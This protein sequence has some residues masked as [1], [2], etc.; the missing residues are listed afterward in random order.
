MSSLRLALKQSL[1]EAAPIPTKDELRAIQRS[2][3]GRK[4]KHKLLKEKLEH[5]RLEHMNRTVLNENPDGNS[6]ELIR[7]IKSISP[8][9]GSN[10]GKGS[11]SGKSNQSSH[12]SNSSSSE[13][14]S[15][16]GSSSDSSGN[17]SSS[18]DNSGSDSDS[19]GSSSSDSSSDS[20]DDDS[21]NKIPSKEDMDGVF[22][23]E[24]SSDEDGNGKKSKL[25]RHLSGN[26]FK[27]FDH[28]DSDP[29]D[30]ATHQP[31]ERHQLPKKLPKSS[32]TSILSRPRSQ[33]PLHTQ[34]HSSQS[35]PDR[36]LSVS[37]SASHVQI[38]RSFPPSIQSN[39]ST[40]KEK[41]S[42]SSSSFTKKKRKEKKGKPKA[43]PA[44]TQPV[45][46]WVMGMSPDKQ[47]RKIMRGMRV[48]VRFVN[49]TLQWYG[50][51]IT[52]VAP[53]GDKV[54]IKYD[55]GTKESAAFPD[56]EIVIDADG[57]GE[58]SPKVEDRVKAFRPKV[59]GIALLGAVP[60]NIKKKKTKKKKKKGE[61]RDGLKLKTENEQKV[62][63][64]I[65]RD[66]LPND[67]VTRPSGNV[68]SSIKAAN[69]T[70][71]AKEE[72]NANTTQNEA[73]NCNVKDTN[74][75]S[76]FRAAD[77]VTSALPSPMATILLQT[78]ITSTE[79]VYEPA[80]TCNVVAG[81][82][83][84]QINSDSE[85]ALEPIVIKSKSE[86]DPTTRKQSVQDIH[87]NTFLSRPL[88]PI[89]KKESTIGSYRAAALENVKASHLDDNAVDALEQN[90]ILTEPAE[91]NDPLQE[92]LA[93][94]KKI[95]PVSR[96][97][98]IAVKSTPV[99]KQEIP[100]EAENRI[101]ETKESRM[102]PKPSDDGIQNG[103]DP[104]QDR[105]SDN[106]GKIS[107]TE[108]ESMS[109]DDNVFNL[110]MQSR[111]AALKAHQRIASNEERVIG[112][113]RGKKRRKDKEDGRR[114]K[115]S[116]SKEDV[117]DW[118]QCDI[119]SKW[120]LIPSVKDLPEKW[121]CQLNVTD[122]K[123][124]F[125]AAVEQTPKEVAR[126][127]KKAKN[128]AVPK[129]NSLQKPK[130]GSDH[131]S[132]KRRNSPNL[133]KSMSE[134][135]VDDFQSST[136][137]KKIASNPSMED[138]DSDNEVLVPQPRRGRRGRRSN[139]EK[140]EGR[141]GRRGRKPKEDKQQEWVQCE[142]CEKW[143][144]LPRHIPAEDLP[145]KWYCS[146]NDWDP[147][148][149]SCAVQEDYKIEDE[150]GKENTFL[151]SNGQG[152]AVGGSKLSYKCLIRRPTR[153][154]TER[155][156]ATE[157]IFSS[158]AAEADGEQSGSQA[159]VLYANSSMFLKRPNYHKMADQH[160]P[161]N[162]QKVSLFDLMNQSQLW[163][164]LYCGFSP[165]AV[166]SYD[167]SFDSL[168][169]TDHGK[170]AVVDTMKVML[171]YT[172]GAKEMSAS[173]ILLDC[174]CR[175]WENKYW[176]ELSAS[177]TYELVCALIDQLI[178]DGLLEVAPQTSSDLESSV[179]ATLYKRTGAPDDASRGQ[180]RKEMENRYASRSMKF[181]KPWKRANHRNETS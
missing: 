49:P 17:S 27:S 10:G 144:R 165:I 6:S 173:D 127:R 156:R 85:I 80:S 101:P 176:I 162:V 22:D 146:L 126:E 172:F 68:L 63:S 135:S 84:Q 159:V 42:I 28:S 133:D 83:E 38:Q 130:E 104:T 99:E 110:S 14:D 125:C 157:S 166:E 167:D 171:F 94:N 100:I 35:D 105:A 117:E 60:L 24:R 30:S 50:G 44:P 72:R 78:T 107:I 132:D 29:D 1:E 154:I 34:M 97:D 18:D 111:K 82:N 128:A 66:M 179:T 9:G 69:S 76:K 152:G 151:T 89:P 75:V 124:S 134:D 108:I 140:A 143:R 23:S 169:N 112:E 145:D 150:K 16:D 81:N 32:A 153:N 180:K 115:K 54:K 59:I 39:S 47:R 114:G 88:S 174:Q 113:T 137:K 155:M 74:I 160:E 149:A 119:C 40:K 175:E 52:A 177:F 33:S 79:T 178:K 118:V 25:S 139:E 36:R 41:R 51:V 70:G 163:K 103:D 87:K 129:R 43:V 181:S 98:S 4:L 96:P 46:A 120:R 57:N 86:Q 67:E 15:D 90:T 56:R 62:K 136:K 158:H 19:D 55:D 73:T 77:I 11:K 170:S 141:Q 58:H 53:K 148:S 164:D 106:E 61:R 5:D 45:L 147:R 93:V 13:S 142:K 21:G 71:A 95:G 92:A 91:S 31:S 121:Y 116:D 2:K 26:R 161:D 48:K 102:S 65:H 138:E 122:P 3:R 168:T 109:D 131:G 37:L 12:R 64:E 7:R 8:V 123:R 20:D